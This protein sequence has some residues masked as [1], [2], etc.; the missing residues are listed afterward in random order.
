MWETAFPHFLRY[1]AKGGI[2]N[3]VQIVMDLGTK[4]SP[5]TI[6]NN[7]LS[8]LGTDVDDTKCMELETFLNNMIYGQNG[9]TNE[10]ERLSN[11]VVKYLEDK[12]QS[13]FDSYDFESN[14]ISTTNKEVGKIE[15][16]QY[17]SFQHTKYI[18][19]NTVQNRLNSALLQIEEL[20]KSGASGPEFNAAIT[21]LQAIVDTAEALL[22]TDEAVNLSGNQHI[23]VTANT[24]DLIIEL[25]ALMQKMSFIGSMAL[26]NYDTGYVFEKILQALGSIQ[27]IDEMTDDLLY[28]EFKQKTDGEKLVNRGSLIQI[29]GVKVDGVTTTGKKGQKSTT[30]QITGHNG[31]TLTIKG[32]FDEK[33]GKM[34]VLFNMPGT[35]D[36]YRV[37]AKNWISMEKGKF[38][39]TPLSSALLRSAGLNEM[40]A[41]GIGLGW[42]KSYADNQTLHEYGKMSSIA[43]IVMGYSQESGYADTIIINDRTAAH[44]YVYS[45]S[46][47]MKKC[48]QNINN[49]K[50]SGYNDGSIESALQDSLDWHTELSGDSQNYMQAIYNALS[51]FQIGVSSGILNLT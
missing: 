15:V 19:Y 28:K 23:D 39:S 51:K 8:R 48:F 31:S 5:S 17:E 10:A 20:T 25:D 3:H 14:L 7:T 9:H 24:K 21:N 22:A 18:Q 41:Y 12:F 30:Y 26:S 1:R 32:V 33:Q 43:D 45:V 13:S 35:D 46:S 40:F 50:L 44:V 6:L 49:L 38:G 37:S 11:I 47:L 42:P 29:A 27:T 34:D 36:K 16:D 4:L 2:M